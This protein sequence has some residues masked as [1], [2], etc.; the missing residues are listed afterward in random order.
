MTL[1]YTHIEPQKPK[2]D[3]PTLQDIPNY[4]YFVFVNYGG[5]TVGETVCVKLPTQCTKDTC[6]AALAIGYTNVCEY[7]S[8]SYV[9]LVILHDLEYSFAP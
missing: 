2:V 9:K 3:P 6:L 7:Q 1:K 4:S 5:T 8:D